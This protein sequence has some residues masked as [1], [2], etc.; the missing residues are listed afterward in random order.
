MRVTV[1]FD[2]T[3]T[4]VQ[5]N[6]VEHPTG[7][8]DVDVFVDRS[9]RDTRE[10]E[11]HLFVDL[12]GAGVT[13]HALQHLVGHLPLVSNSKPGRLAQGSKIVAV[14]LIH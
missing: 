12:F 2:A 11:S 14:G 4:M 7:D 1:D 10:F 8:K 6:V 9:E 3:R 13:R 5:A